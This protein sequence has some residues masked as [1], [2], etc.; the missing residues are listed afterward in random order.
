MTADAAERVE[1]LKSR[2]FANA[3]LYDP[4]GVG[5]THVMYVLHH[6]DRPALYSGLPANPKVSPLVRVWKGAT[7]PLALGALVLAAVVGFVNYV[8]TGP[9]EVEPEDELAAQREKEQIHG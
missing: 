2:G 3:G 4:A 9:K 5:G 6:A 7:K 1:E 8:R